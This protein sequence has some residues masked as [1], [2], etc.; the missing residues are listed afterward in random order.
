MGGRLRGL[1][2]RKGG[3]EL[4]P[5]VFIMSVFLFYFYLFLKGVG[6]WKERGNGTDYCL[7]YLLCLSFYKIKYILKKR[8][9]DGIIV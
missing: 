5:G 6:G 2:K 3:M 4:L 7:G 9:G 8:G 1:G